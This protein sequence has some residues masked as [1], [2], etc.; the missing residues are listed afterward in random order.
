MSPDGS[1]LVQRLAQALQAQGVSVG[2]CEKGQWEK[3]CGETNAQA[4]AMQAGLFIH[5]ELD[6]ATRRDPRALLEALRSVL[7]PQ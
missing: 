7:A 1:D 6:E 4:A 5:I 2:V 3:L